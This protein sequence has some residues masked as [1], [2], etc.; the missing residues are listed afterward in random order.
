MITT[1]LAP[2][3]TALKAGP[4][5]AGGATTTSKTLHLEPSGKQQP[6][7]DLKSHLAAA[8]PIEQERLRNIKRNHGTKSLGEVTVDQALGGMRA[9]PGMLWEVSLLDAEEGIRLRGHTIAEL[10]RTLPTAIE[11]GEPLPEGLLWLLLTGEI[12]T[13]EQAASV[14]EELRRRAALPE[15]VYR[16]LE[17]MPADAHPMTQF[18]AGILALQPGS[19]FAKAYET[20]IPKAKYWEPIFE[21]SLDLIAKLPAI[22]AAV[23]RK[24]FHGGDYIAPDPTLDWAANL[25]H[26]MG[27]EDEGCREMMRMYLTIHADHEGGNVS[28]HATHLVG[29]ALSDPY[30]CLAAGITGL[31]GPLHGLA[32]QEVLRWMFDVQKTLGPDPSKEELTEFVWSTLNA[33]KVV[34][35]YG[36]AVLRTTD[37]R[38]TCQREFALKHMPDDPLFK[39]CSS[40]YEVVPDVLLKTG[41]V[42]NPYPNV[43]SHSGVLLQY[44]GIK[45]ESFYTVLFGVSRAL[46]VLAQGIWSRALGFPLERPKSLTMGLIEKKF[47]H[48][49]NN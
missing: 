9:I 3:V 4:A 29:S 46:G 49:N 22:A 20:G 40:L 28:A 30:L 31:A 8:I 34:P 11:G 2:A 13:N 33:G 6:V 19:V 18:A 37:P 21:D 42:K 44:Y 23:Y 43:D 17:A 36:H 7:S 35:G 32:N 24:T 27:F 48:A 15:Y 47:A 25:A 10:Q 38:Y 26:M 45:E 1:T 41:K 14:S 5:A 39:L 12:P 16:V